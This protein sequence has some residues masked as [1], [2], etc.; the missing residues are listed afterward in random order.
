MIQSFLEL[1]E[2]YSVVEVNIE[3]SVCLSHSFES[4]IDLDPEQVQDSLEGATLVLGLVSV[5]AVNV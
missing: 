3:I 4:F 5:T 2:R 1:I